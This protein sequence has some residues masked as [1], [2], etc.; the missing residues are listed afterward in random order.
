MFN[1][2]SPHRDPVGFGGQY[3]YYT[4]YETNLLCLTHRYYDSGTGRFVTRDP[5]GYN[6]GINLDRKCCCDRVCGLSTKNLPRK[7]I[8]CSEVCGQIRV[9]F[10]TTRAFFVRMY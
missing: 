3:G 5:I 7:F 1:S 2:L 6:G 4:D 9:V 10:S 8:M